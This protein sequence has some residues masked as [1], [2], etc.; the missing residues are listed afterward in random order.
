MMRPINPHIVT[1]QIRRAEAMQAARR[2]P[3]EKG[4]FVRLAWDWQRA[5]LR[6]IRVER[7]SRELDLRAP[8][9]LDYAP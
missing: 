9:P 4:I 1:C 6:A 8:R 7:D 2:F 3:S 5:L